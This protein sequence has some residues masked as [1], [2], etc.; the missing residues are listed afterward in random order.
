[1]KRDLY[2]PY[3]KDKKV[4]MLGLGLLGRG[5]GDTAFMST[6]GSSLIVTDKKTKEDLASSLE[7]LKEYTGITYVL[8][9]H[10][11]E[12]FENR[13][14][15]M[16]A[17]GVPLDS[18]F[19][20]HAIKNNI[21][22]YMSAALVSSI[23][24]EKLKD[25]TIVGIT[26]TRGKST[27]TEL[28]A[29]ILRKAGE[30][31]HVGG[32]IRGV[33]NLPLLE[34]TEE[35]DYLVLELDSWQLQGYR[36]LEISPDVAVFTTF[37]DDHL[38]YYHN[39]RDAYFDDKAQIFLHQK[40]SCLIAS[41]QAAGEIKKRKSD[42][43]MIVPEVKQFDARIIGTHNDVSISLA[44]EAATRCGISRESALEYA[45][46]F[47]PVEGRLQKVKEVKGVTIYNDNN[48]TT[49]DAT[50][51]G[52]EAVYEKY[53][54][55]PIL[56]MGGSDKNLP[57]D[58][59]EETVREKTK[60]CVLLAGTGTD[61]LSL[62]KENIHETLEDCIRAAFAAS[63]PGDIILFSPGFASFSNYFK[64]EYERNDIFMSEINRI[65]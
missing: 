24:K 43:E 15:I 39:D 9:E 41:E 44:V 26:G 3:F 45:K 2:E 4:T 17:A 30:R 1:M 10:R 57:L 48:A 23:V 13:D 47:E 56:I 7:S 55:K 46:T 62:S 58:K 64:N 38:N 50:I 65:Q 12:D 19:V 51:A 32:N 25:V 59:L 18:E 33:A 54:R 63:L 29:H 53:G 31:V 35:G 36:D 16:K 22:V 52:I 42:Q 21:P 60:E 61:K 8:G 34:V 37:L 14:F 27:A 5:V 11:L 20:L 40:A 6:H 49:P 28:I